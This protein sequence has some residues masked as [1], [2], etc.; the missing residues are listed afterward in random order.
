MRMGFASVRNVKMNPKL[1][2]I[3]IEEIMVKYNIKKENLVCEFSAWR[4]I[5]GS[6]KN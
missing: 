5:F 2:R 6:K 1:I 4:Y 3:A